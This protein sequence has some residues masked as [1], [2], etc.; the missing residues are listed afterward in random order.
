M[1]IE[2]AGAAHGVL[3]QGVVHALVLLLKH[4]AVMGQG[5]QDRV[6]VCSCV[7]SEGFLKGSSVRIID[8]IGIGFYRHSA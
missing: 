1:D 2:E 3:L 7:V 5:S 6:T 8:I 4:A